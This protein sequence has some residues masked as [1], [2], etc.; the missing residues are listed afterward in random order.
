MLLLV[1]SDRAVVACGRNNKD[2]YVLSY[3]LILTYPFSDFRVATIIGHMPLN[4][5]MT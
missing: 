4:C 3:V 2:V 5:T 1:G